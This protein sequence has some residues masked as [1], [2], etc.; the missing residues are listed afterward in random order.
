MANGSKK[1]NKTNKTSKCKR[2][3]SLKLGAE[4]RRIE[5]DRRKKKK[6]KIGDFGLNGNKSEAESAKSFFHQISLDE[7]E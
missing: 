3:L 5:E 6:K 7:K 4:T 1:K 2:N